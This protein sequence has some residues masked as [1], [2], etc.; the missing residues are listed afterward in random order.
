MATMRTGMRALPLL[1][2]AL[3]LATTAEAARD[4]WA[5][6]EHAPTSCEVANFATSGCLFEDCAR[7]LSCLGGLC[8]FR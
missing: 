5:D 4:I 7:P 3:L 8:Y 2:A 6:Y 1:L